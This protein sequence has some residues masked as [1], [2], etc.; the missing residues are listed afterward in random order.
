MMKILRVGVL[1][2]SALLML[3]GANWLM[4]GGA[5]YAQSRSAAKKGK[6]KNKANV[7]DKKEEKPAVQKEEL[8]TH[9]GG[10]LLSTSFSSDGK[11]AVSVSSEGDILFFDVESGKKTRSIR[12]GIKPTAATFFGNKKVGLAGGLDKDNAIFVLDLAR[13]K[14]TRTLAGH[15]G[16]VKTLA[17]TN[18]GE[19]ILS[20]G[21]NNQVTLWGAAHGDI[22][23]VFK[24]HDDAVNAV[25]VSHDRVIAASGSADGKIKIW[26]MSTGELV[27]TI[28]AYKKGVLKVAFSPD[29][30]FILSGGMEKGKDKKDIY[31]IKL[32]NVATGKPLLRKR[33]L[34]D[35]KRELSVAIFSPNGKYVL[36]GDRGGALKLWDVLAKTSGVL[37]TTATSTAEVRSFEGHAGGILTATFSP[38]GSYVLAGGDGTLTIWETETGK[39]VGGGAPAGIGIPPPQETA[40]AGAVSPP[41]V[42]PPAGAVPAPEVAP[43]AEVAPLPKG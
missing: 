14:E 26:N 7:E 15:K 10:N 20:G 1:V 17:F 41:E 38:D 23:R 16:G 27:K 13:G 5:A 24:D 32:W 22:V 9:A 29:D 4:D 36:S 18:D 31:P 33:N 12:Y 8:W 6:G 42:A 3:D 21:W 37:P 11:S 28:S 34:G 2:I 43:P 40:P 30:K 39:I 35:H 19:S 25:A